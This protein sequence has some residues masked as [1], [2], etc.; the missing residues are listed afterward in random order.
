MHK[1]AIIGLGRIGSTLEDDP[2][3]DKPAS[4]AG[5][6]YRHPKTR[7][8]AAC[9]IDEQRLTTFGQRW[10]IPQK[11]LYSDYKKLLKNE[12]PDIVSVASWTQTH[13]NI[14]VA[15]A[16]VESVKAIYCEKPIAT[17]LRE[18]N[19]MISVCRKNGVKL[20]VG[21]ERRFDSNFV[22]VKKLID[23]KR[24]GPLKTIIGHALSQKPPKLKSDKYVGGA[25]YHDGT[26]LMDLILYYGGEAKWVT[27]FDERPNG[28]RYIEST[29]VG[30]IRL[31]SGVNVFVEG[32]GEREYFKFDLDLQFEKGRILIGNSGISVFSSEKS[33]NYSGFKELSPAAF[34]APKSSVKNSFTGAVDALVKSIKNGKEPVSNGVEARNAL[35]LI[36]SMYKSASQGGKRIYIR[37]MSGR[38]G[39]GN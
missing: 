1:V 13:Y 7:I 22:N 30:L 32:G 34:D 14:T 38:A 3:R 18:A 20:I 21:H 11:S 31:K 9:D 19:K 24:F 28:K 33:K 35:D 12:K 5:A 27:A 4:H 37:A 39:K 10:A 17:N 25:L 15:A 23:K 2:L 8:V 26:H 6:F 36:L 29:A 16:S